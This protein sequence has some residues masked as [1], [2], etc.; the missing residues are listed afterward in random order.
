MDKISA[1]LIFG[2]IGMVLLSGMIVYRTWIADVDKLDE[3]DAV[4]AEVP[5][6]QELICNDDTSITS[7]A[8]KKLWLRVKIIYREEYDADGYQVISEAV[9][10]GEWI[11]KDGWYYYRVPLELA[12]TTRPLMDRLLYGGQEVEQGETGRF[13]LQVEAV[14]EAWL[15]ERPEDAYQAFRDFTA[16]SPIFP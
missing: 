1:A 10:D 6:Q 3:I 15:L 5:L 8:N 7:N 2:I 9:S 16:L 14:D 4:T 13:S 12:Q 11:E